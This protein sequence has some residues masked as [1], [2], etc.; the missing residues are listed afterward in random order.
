MSDEKPCAHD[1]AEAFL[2]DKNFHGEKLPFDDARI[3]A[4]AQMMDS[5]IPNSDTWTKQQ[6]LRTK[7]RE[8][9][10]PESEKN[11]VTKEQAA[12]LTASARLEA[13]NSQTL[14]PPGVGLR[15]PKP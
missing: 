1:S 6:W 14:P 13:A 15:K 9:P 8:M 4:I 7:R 5:E 3:P 10:K 11:K 2:R 12:P